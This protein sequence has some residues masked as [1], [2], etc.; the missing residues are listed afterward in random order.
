M[1]FSDTSK[2]LTVG[3]VSVLG[4]IAGSAAVALVSGTFR[5]RASPM[6][7]TPATISWAVS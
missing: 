5:W 2:V 6:R 1:F 4:V 7:R 3:I